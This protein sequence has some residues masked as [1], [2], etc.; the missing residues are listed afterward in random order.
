VI[1][2]GRDPTF[3]RELSQDGDDQATQNAFHAQVS[4]PHR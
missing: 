2:N 1:G 4:C 3:Q